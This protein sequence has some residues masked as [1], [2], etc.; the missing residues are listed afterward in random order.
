MA[1]DRWLFGITGY[2]Y[3][4]AIVTG[5][6]YNTVYEGGCRF[7]TAWVRE[8]E[9]EKASE[10]RQRKREGEEADKVEVAPGMTVGNLG[11]FRTALIGPTHKLP[12]RRRQR[13]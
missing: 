11:R 12:K 9:K 8:E 10:I 2:W 3:T 6:W 7:M 5:A 1:K 4:A 13:R